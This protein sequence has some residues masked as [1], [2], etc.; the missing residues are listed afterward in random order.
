MHRFY[1]GTHKPV[2]LTRTDVPL[3]VSRRSLNEYANLPR[4][5]GPWA[6][7][8]GGFTELTLHDRWVTPISRYIEDVRRYVTE[9]GNMDWAAPQ[10]WMCEPHMLKKTGKTIEEHQILTTY[11]YL[12]LRWRAPELPWVP[13]LQG[14]CWGDHVRH[15]EIYQFHGVDL[16]KAPVVGIGSVCRRQNTER[17]V[18]LV[19]EVHDELPGVRLHGFGFKTDGLAGLA[20]LPHYEDALW[21]ADS[22]AWS[23]QARHIGKPV[24]GAKHKHCGNCM[25]YALGWREH[26]LRKVNTARMGLEE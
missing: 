12:E 16:E 1:L 24:C 6:L 2:W 23:K 14:W 7:D 8:S 21:S 3:F 5:I 18:L 19:A 13:V 25:T 9:I 22:M 17:G 10:D 4:A 20:G 11:N 15:A 26:L